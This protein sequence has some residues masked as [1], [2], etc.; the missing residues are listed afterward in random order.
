MSRID[1]KCAC[2]ATFTA[3]GLFMFANGDAWRLTHP[4]TVR[5]RPMWS[6]CAPPAVKAPVGRPD[7]SSYEQKPAR[8]GVAANG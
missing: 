2:G 7:T 3:R 6:T 1:E 4:C 8:G 5:D